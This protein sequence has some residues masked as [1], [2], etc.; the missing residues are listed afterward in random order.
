MHL[1]VGDRLLVTERGGD[2][3]GRVCRVLSIRGPE[4]A[5][6][7]VVLRYDTGHEELLV[8]DADLVIR[9][10]TDAQV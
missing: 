5:P 1:R 7:Y 10:L 8:P 3:S 2:E 4:G 6:P 9:V